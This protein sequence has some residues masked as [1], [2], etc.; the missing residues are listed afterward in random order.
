MINVCVFVAVHDRTPAPSSYALLFSSRVSTPC[1]GNQPRNRTSKT[2]GPLLSENAGNRRAP[3][4]QM[5]N[6]ICAEHLLLSAE[7]LDNEEQL[8]MFFGSTDSMRFR[9]RRTSA[10][11]LSA[12]VVKLTSACP[13][14]NSSFLFTSSNRIR[15][16]TVVSS[17]CLHHQ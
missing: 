12:F 3:K 9:R 6:R 14:E 8:R 11:L 15:S 13:L 7:N 4:L 2:G 1:F 16:S 10:G 5:C 17:W